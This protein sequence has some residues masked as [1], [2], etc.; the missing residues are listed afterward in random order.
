MSIQGNTDGKDEGTIYTDTPPFS[1]KIL[2]S[3]L[4]G[5]VSGICYIIEINSLRPC[6]DEW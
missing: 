4:D 2:G 3:E 5:S 6:R 1:G